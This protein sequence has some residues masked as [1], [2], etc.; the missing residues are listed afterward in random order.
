[1]VIVW[2]IM[3][4][5]NEEGGAGGGAVDGRLSGP[6]RSSLSFCKRLVR[7]SVFDDGA[8]SGGDEG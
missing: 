7:R 4:G 3:V 1:M 2:V 6:T 5:E 8:G